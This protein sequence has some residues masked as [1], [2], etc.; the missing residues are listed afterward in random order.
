MDR[1]EIGVGREVVDREREEKRRR[2]KP[3]WI[4]EKKG[5]RGRG[6]VCVCV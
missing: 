5:C 2:E 1:E 3:G 6:S 4:E